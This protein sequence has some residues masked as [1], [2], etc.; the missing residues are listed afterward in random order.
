LI[1]LVPVLDDIVRD[2]NDERRTIYPLRGECSVR[3]AAMLLL[4]SF[5]TDHATY[6]N[7]SVLK[8]LVLPKLYHYCTIP[9]LAMQLFAKQVAKTVYSTSASGQSFSESNA[10]QRGDKSDPGHYW[11]SETMIVD[12]AAN[13]N[14]EYCDEALGRPRPGR[15]ASAFAAVDNIAYLI[16]GMHL[17]A[18]KYAQSTLKDDLETYVPVKTGQPGKESVDLWDN[19]CGFLKNEEANV[20]LIHGNAG[21]GKSLLGR[22]LELVLWEIH[23]ENTCVVPIFIP[24]PSIKHPVHNVIREP[25]LDAG[26]TSAQIQTLRQ[27]K[28]VSFLFILD[29]F[30][31]ISVKANLYR[32][33]DFAQWPGQ[34]IITARTEYLQEL[35]DYHSFFTASDQQRSVMEFYIR[36][37]DVSQQ[38]AFFTKLIKKGTSKWRDVESYQAAINDIP[39][40]NTLITTPFMLRIVCMVLEDLHRDEDITEEEK[41]RCVNVCLV[42]VFYLFLFFV[43]VYGSFV[44]HTSTFTRL[45]NIILSPLPFLFV[46]I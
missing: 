8:A 15:V 6:G 25:L 19:V 32:S 36:P 26:F 5:C 17:N 12:Q 3:E 10:A 39:G 21:S 7:S 13:P 24:L 16:E 14:F 4:G 42:V 40:L 30:D 43:F 2:R 44:S 37:F 1:S 28:T 34:V 31:E 29:G 41:V 33:N 18:F 27:S 9:E 38:V 23:Q 11:F 45:I 20:L 46:N 22:Y 35:G